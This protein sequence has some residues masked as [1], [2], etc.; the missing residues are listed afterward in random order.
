MHQS[1][2][3]HKQRDVSTHVSRRSSKTAF[4]NHK[5]MKRSESNWTDIRHST[6]VKIDTFN[7]LPANLMKSQ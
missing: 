6:P 4:S 1:N 7:W 3:F 5:K 2:G